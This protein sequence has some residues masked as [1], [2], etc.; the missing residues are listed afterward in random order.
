MLKDKGLQRKQTDKFYTK[1]CVVDQCIEFVKQ[2]VSIH[3][4]ND[5]I[6]EPSAGN[7]SFIE[8]IQQLCYY[9]VFVDIEPEHH[10]ITPQDYLTFSL[11][12]ERHFQSIHVIG[13]P[14]FGRQSSLARK[15]I[16]KSSS[17]AKS[18]SFILPKSF[19]KDSLKTAFP[20]QY[21]LVF[22]VDLPI[23]SF[24]IE[25]KEHDVPCVFQIWIQ[26]NYSRSLPPNLQP[27]NFIFVTKTESPHLSFRRVGVYAG[28]I[29]TLIEDKNIQSHYFIRFT[30]NK[31][32]EENLLLLQDVSFEEKHHTVGP[33]SISK[34][35]IIAKFNPILSETED[36][37]P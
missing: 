3:Y 9:C 28:K 8:A 36:N 31:S 15:F 24:V 27:S 30:N 17:F 25:G 22:E 19:K 7:G 29:D 16:Q 5:L 4:E 37:H 2:Y 21:H 1:K 18:I 14:P 34:Q 10:Y 26:K 35:E 11:P 12:Q 13:N 32:I 33:K 20:V 23:N 6:I